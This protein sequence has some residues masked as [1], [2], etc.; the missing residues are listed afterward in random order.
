[1]RKFFFLL[2]AALFIGFVAWAGS[3]TGSLAGGDF[4]AIGVYPSQKPL[5][6][7]WASTPW[8]SDATGSNPTENAR[9]AQI[10]VVSGAEIT[11][12]V[13]LN[14]PAAENAPRS[15]CPTS[16]TVQRGDTASAIALRCG[17]DVNQLLGANPGLQNANRI[18]IGQVLTIPNGSSGAV[19]AAAPMGAPLGVSNAS[20]TY[21]QGSGF[22]AGAHFHYGVGLPSSGYVAIGEG[23]ADAQGAFRLPFQLPAQMN[24]EPRAFL[25]VTTTGLPNVQAITA[26]MP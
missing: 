5:P 6:T 10:K 1:M 21:L 24:L 18:Y 4:S 16:I 15:D 20:A 3:L 12:T 25:L 2:L 13:H 19:E 26:L 23:Q 9:Q 14:P 22:P 17:I 7:P 11:P 8:A